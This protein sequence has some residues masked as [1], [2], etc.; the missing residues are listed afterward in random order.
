MKRHLV[1]AFAFALVLASCGTKKNKGSESS[2]TNE[3]SLAMCDVDTVKREQLNPNGETALAL[4]MRKMDEDLRAAKTS[5]KEGKV[6]DYS[7]VHDAI[8]TA[9]PTKKHIIGDPVF[10]SFSDVY[11]NSIKA[12]KESPKDSIPAMHN[13]IIM[14]C[15]EC[16]KSYCTG[17][18]TRIKK[19]RINPEK[20]SFISK[21]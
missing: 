15:I 18:I 20:V 21:D 14:N 5:M 19:L 2:K 6:P 7:F 1:L 17:P 12:I 8:K 9:E 16:H 13:N 4:L 10:A 3:D 11:L